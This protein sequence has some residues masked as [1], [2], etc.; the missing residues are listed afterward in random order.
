MDEERTIKIDP[1]VGNLLILLGRILDRP[2][3]DIA[4]DALRQFA[5]S[6]LATLGE[7]AHGHSAVVEAPQAQRVVGLDDLSSTLKNLNAY[8]MVDPDFTR[9][10]ADFV[11]AEVKATTDPAQ[12]F[13]VTLLE[14]PDQSG[15]IQS[16]LLG[17]LNE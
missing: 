17:L 11:E 14:Q 9:A 3:S 8:R 5:V 10:M 12:G 1:N 2:V 13:V 16:K 7:K 15:Q 4:S 6:A